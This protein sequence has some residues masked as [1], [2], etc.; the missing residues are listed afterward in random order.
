[1]NQPPNHTPLIVVCVTVMGMTAALAGSWL[2]W[3]GFAGGGELVVTLNSA[4]SGLVGFLGGRA[5][6]NPNTATTSTVTDAGAVVTTETN[7]EPEPPKKGKVKKHSREDS[8]KIHPL[9][10][11]I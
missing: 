2:L 11:T 1:M 8:K 7:P 3:K 9:L 4:I 10:S 5:M 6:N